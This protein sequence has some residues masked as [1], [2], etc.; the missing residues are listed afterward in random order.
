MVS[1][2]GSCVCEGGRRAC[3]LGGDTLTVPLDLNRFVVDGAR[4]RELDV[5]GDG[6]RP[7]VR[8]VR[9]RQWIDVG[10]RK[11]RSVGDGVQA[12]NLYEMKTGCE[13]RGAQGQLLELLEF[14]LQDRNILVLGI[15]TICQ[16]SFDGSPEEVPTRVVK[17]EREV[18]QK[19]RA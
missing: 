14:F 13:L 3:E 1:F 11:E 15:V 5:L 12:N 9:R 17:R 4:P 10:E 19:S 16:A 6:L 18:F 8:R 2:A 7:K